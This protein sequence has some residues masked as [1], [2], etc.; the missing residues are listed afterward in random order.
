MSHGYSFSPRNAT[1]LLRG[2]KIQHFS[3]QEL[4]GI[5][6]PHEQPVLG[7]YV[8]KKTGIQH[9]ATKTTTKTLKRNEKNTSLNFK[10]V[11][12]FWWVCLV[13]WPWHCSSS[14]DFLKRE[15]AQNQLHSSY[16]TA[17][18][19]ENALNKQKGISVKPMEPV[20]VMEYRCYP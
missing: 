6:E 18:P 9:I 10:P 15:M 4:K 13:C 3:K 1:I 8:W 5:H 17:V 11:V 14:Q 19:Q 20:G 16:Q 12:I 7:K 2:E